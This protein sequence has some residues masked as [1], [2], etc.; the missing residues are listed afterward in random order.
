VVL[1]LLIAVAG[2]VVRQRALSEPLERIGW[3]DEVQRIDWERIDRKDG[4]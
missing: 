3:V 4:S 1:A 2:W